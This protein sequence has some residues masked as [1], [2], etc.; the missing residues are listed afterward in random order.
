[1]RAVKWLIILT[2]KRKNVGNL[3]NAD[4]KTDLSAFFK[5]FVLS[6]QRKHHHPFCPSI[7][8]QLNPKV[9]REKDKHDKIVRLCVTEGGLEFNLE[10]NNEHKIKK[11]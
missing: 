8:H 10:S 2:N 11:K 4:N 9:T 6:M 7:T 5:D 3:G 1:M